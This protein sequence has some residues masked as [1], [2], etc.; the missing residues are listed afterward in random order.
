MLT[1]LALL[2]TSATACAFR[3]PLE[4]VIFQLCKSHGL[5]KLLDAALNGSEQYVSHF[6]RLPLRDLKGNMKEELMVSKTLLE[7]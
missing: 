2:K 5:A 3:L 1:V 6:A 4:S 7:V